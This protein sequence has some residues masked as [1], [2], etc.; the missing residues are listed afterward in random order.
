MALIRDAPRGLGGFRFAP[1]EEIAPEPRPAHQ[2]FAGLANRRKGAQPLRES[3]RERG[4]VHIGGWLRGGGKKQTRLQK[5]E[6]RGHDQI[7]GGELEPQFPRGLDEAQILLRQRE[8]G[9]ARQ[10]DPL[11]PGELQ[12][13]VERAFEAIEVD[14]ESGLARRLGEVE[15]SPKRVRCQRITSF[16]HRGA[17]AGVRQGALRLVSTRCSERESAQNIWFPGKDVFTLTTFAGL[18]HLNL[19]NVRIN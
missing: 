2:I 6:P 17:P 14:G 8:D 1:G 5:G 9:D 11:A 15:I 12:Q 3:L 4:R 10:I 7:V 18:I 13:Q 19:R 16:A